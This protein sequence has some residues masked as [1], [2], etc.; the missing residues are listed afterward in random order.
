MLEARGL[1]AGYGD[2][3]VVRD[4]DVRVDRGEVVALLGPNGSGKSTTLLTLAGE[5]PLLAG[6]VRWDGASTTAPLHRRAR[7]GLAFVPEERSVLMS[8][9]V[10]DNLLLGRGGIDPVVEM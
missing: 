6:E 10:R 9:S 7:G 2:I 1:S 4:V 5:L 8:M 3:V